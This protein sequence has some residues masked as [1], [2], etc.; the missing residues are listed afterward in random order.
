MVPKD[1]GKGALAFRFIKETMKNDVSAGKG[2]LNGSG[3]RLS[4]SGCW[5]K[6]SEKEQP[7]DE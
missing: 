7:R 3:R 4:G 2:D 6:E 5:E 1:G